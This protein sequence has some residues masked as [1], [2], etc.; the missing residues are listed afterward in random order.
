MEEKNNTSIFQELIINQRKDCK[1]NKKLSL[2]DMKRIAKNLKTSIFNKN[3][4]SIWNG[5]ITNYNKV[6]KPNYINFYFRHKKVALHRLLFEN[7]ITELGDD[8]YLKFNCKNKGC[9]VNINHMYTIKQL[10]KLPP[11]IIKKNVENKE[12]RK[13]YKNLVVDFD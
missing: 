9:C 11:P 4:C 12:N 1:D 3:E 5:Y 7:Y 6:D 10:H 8:Q 2:S 13:K